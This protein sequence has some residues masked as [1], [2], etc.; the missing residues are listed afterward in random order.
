MIY[1]Q[2]LVAISEQS[3]IG[4][5]R[6]LT[7]RIATE[8]GLGETHMGNASIVASELATNLVRH[9]SGG[10]LL[11]RSLEDQQ[12]PAIELIAIDRGPGM[13]H[14]GR[15]LE[16]G[17]S[18]A[19]TAGNGL[20]AIRRLASEF[21]IFSVPDEGTIVF[22][23]IRRDAAAADKTSRFDWGIVNRPAP[24][25]SECGDTWRIV[26][27]ADQFSLMVA[28]GLGHGPQAAEAA[29]V[30][31]AVFVENNYQSLSDF[32]ASA[33]RRMRGTRGAAVAI[34]QVNLATG[35]LSYAGVGNIAGAIRA[36]Q[37]DVRRGLMSHNGTVGVE[38]RKV[39]QLEYPMTA[40]TVLIMHSD[41]LQQRWSLDKYP[42]LIN[43]HPAV[44]AGVLYRDFTRGRDDV[45]VCVVR[46][47]S[48]LAA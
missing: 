41:G 23:R 5:A 31:A 21:D 22:A 27:N 46:P 12:G 26:S 42:G 20:G 34:A 11:V 6:R 9:S 3:Q 25:E 2:L 17:F 28:D 15:C 32:M 39:Q 14:V 45:T 16:D 36:Q 10:E 44:I 38:M 37:S 13:P 19:G 43:R 30:A 40:D 47:R 48:P 18:T 1:C 35:I 4:E 7:N 24:Y 29:N 8:A 33:D